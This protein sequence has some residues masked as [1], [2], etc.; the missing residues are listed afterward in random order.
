MDQVGWQGTF[1][2]RPLP[3]QQM[4]LSSRCRLVDRVPQ[5]QGVRGGCAPRA[6]GADL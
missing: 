3:Q 1:V 5:W 4:S 2:P 6:R